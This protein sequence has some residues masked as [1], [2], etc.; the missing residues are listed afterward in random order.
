MAPVCARGAARVPL[1]MLRDAA[2][3]AYGLIVDGIGMPAP[4]VEHDRGRD[5]RLDLYVVDALPEG[6][7]A[8]DGVAIG[9]GPLDLLSDR[10]AAPAFL[11]VDANALGGGR[12]PLARGLAWGVAEARAAGVDV[13][14]TRVV[15][16]GLS[17]YLA[18]LASGCAPDHDAHARFE[19]APFRALTASAEGPHAL[20]TWLDRTRSGGGGALVPA[21]EGLASQH[22]GLAFGPQEDGGEPTSAHFV[23]AIDLFDVLRETMKE[24]HTTLDALLLDFT[25]ARAFDPIA[26]PPLEWAVPASTLP[27][28][29]LVSRGIEPTGAT[30][31][32]VDLDGEPRPSGL[33]IELKWEIGASFRWAV[34]KLDAEGTKVGE[35]PV[36]MVERLREIAVDVRHLEG[37]AAVLVVGW[38]AGDPEHPWAPDP[39]LTL[40]HGY[41]IAIY[42][43]AP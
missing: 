7:E 41:E 11:L 15:V 28:R 21:L 36:A 5:G 29:L 16:D 38:N 23:N 31:A 2:V 6:V 33:E 3:E 39:P 42:A 30:Y 43:E 24:Q 4:L 20:A 18:D 19:K 34:L 37:A 27:R 32:R 17:R 12:C 13:A 22:A 35:V 1:A 26:K 10:D 9:R 40:P 14:E 25:V 8:Y